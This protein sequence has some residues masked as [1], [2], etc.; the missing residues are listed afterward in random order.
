MILKTFFSKIAE[1]KYVVEV[2]VML[3]MTIV[4]LSI[5]STLL[6]RH[7]V[8]LNKNYYST[9]KQLIIC[10][11]EKTAI[12]EQAT[13]L[14]SLLTF[15][16]IKTSVEPEIVEWAYKNAKQYIPR[17]T[18][19]PIL[20]EAKK[21]KNYLM[22]ISVITEES[23]FN[24]FARSPKG[25][26]GLG[27]VITKKEGKWKG[28]FTELVEQNILQEEI[29]IF[30]YRKNIAAIDY[31]LTKYRAEK[32]S[33]REALKAYVNGSSSYVTKVLSNFAEMSLILEELKDNPIDELVMPIG[34]L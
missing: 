9:Y 26:K 34:D 25:A 17:S 29:D 2:V 4:I 16:N 7:N 12:I 18:V 1:S 28:W 14:K 27:Q 32:G 5:M 22:I 33:W 30:D 11:K 10:V 13:H 21:Y 23:G 19:I 8:K 3:I 31:I 20:Q 24:P 15:D 6:Y